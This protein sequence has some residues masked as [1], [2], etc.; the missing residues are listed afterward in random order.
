M[1]PRYGPT[2]F[3]AAL[4]T[5]AVFATV[6]WVWTPYVLLSLYSFGVASAIVLPVAGLLLLLGNNAA[7]VGRGILIGYLATPLT[8]AIVI[9][10]VAVFACVT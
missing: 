3:V 5:V 4:V 7:Q 2:G 6:T 1:A 10:P 8:A 9:I